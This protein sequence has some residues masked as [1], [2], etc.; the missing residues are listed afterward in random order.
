MEKTGEVSDAVVKAL[1][2]AEMMHRHDASGFRAGNRA[3]CKIRQR[4]T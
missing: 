1:G 4:R 2:E 3:D